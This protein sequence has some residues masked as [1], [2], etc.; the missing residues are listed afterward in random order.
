MPLFA[1]ALGREIDVCTAQ[2]GVVH[3]SFENA[4]NLMMNGDMWTVLDAA[5]PD[6]P[7]G[8]RLASGAAALGARVGDPVHVRVGYLGVGRRVIDC[9][10][11]SRWGPAPWP[12]PAAGLAARLAAVEQAA[13]GRAWEASAAMACDL[14]QALHHSD[15]ELARAVRRSVGRGP[16]LTPAGDDVLVGMLALLTSGAAGAAGAQAARRLAAA[17]APVLATTPDISRQLLLQALRGLPGRALHDLGHALMVGGP[18]AVLADAIRVAL[19]SGATS[20]ADACLGLAAS[21]RFS[22]FNA[23]RLAA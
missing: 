11:A 2:A 10:S 9:R 4:V 3:G 17:L 7:F 14:G 1:I 16:G 6:G 20:G 23:Q 19:E 22:F 5:R 12:R 15:A 21:C 13:R 18:G 8:I